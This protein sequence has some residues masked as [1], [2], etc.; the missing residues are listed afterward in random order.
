MKRLFL[1][2]FLAILLVMPALAAVPPAAE[3]L[4]AGRVDEA[5]VSLRSRLQAVPNDAE[6]F[7]LLMRAH[8]AMQQWDE[9]IAAGVKATSL[10]PNKRLSSLARP[11]LRRKGRP[12]QLGL[13]GFACQEESHRI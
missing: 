5:V 10:A 2:C 12:R 1:S 7:A 13:G 9:A 8:F 3:L 11:L 6:A 4:I